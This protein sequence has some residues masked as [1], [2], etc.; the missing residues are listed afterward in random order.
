MMSKFS[1]VSFGGPVRIIG[2]GAYASFGIK[3]TES[4]ARDATP[5]AATA[6]K[7]PVK[8]RCHDDRSRKIP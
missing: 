7:F 6:W 1:L 8:K 5:I 3:S 4:S 2:T